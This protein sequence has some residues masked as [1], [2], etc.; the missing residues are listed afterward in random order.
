MARPLKA[1]DLFC[2]AGGAGFG[3]HLAGFQ[4]TGVDIQPQPHY[5][6]DFVQGD[7]LA[8]LRD[9][10]EEI[11]QEFDLI[12]ASPPCQYFARVTRWRGKAEDH[13]DLID[14]TRDLL[15]ETGLPYVLE[16]VL[17]APIRRD[18]VLCGSM[19][20]LNVRR[21]RAFETS[22]GPGDPPAPCDHHA[23]LLPFAHKGERAYA[24]AMGCTWMSKREGRQAIPPAYTEFI[25]G[26]AVDQI[27]GRVAA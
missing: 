1:L 16:N 6:F 15:E 4:V 19:F 27:R 20:G 25:G 7:A 23:G 8:Y 9:N 21:H 2:C 26:H 13:P 5:P 14:P 11:R 24:D 12:H 3:Y 22:W 18:Y 17:E 10:M